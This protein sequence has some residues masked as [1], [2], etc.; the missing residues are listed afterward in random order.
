MARIV[1]QADARAALTTQAGH[2]FRIVDDEP[3]V[4]LGNN[5][6]TMVGGEFTAL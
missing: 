6:H 3:G 2:R 1:V 5:L 4:H